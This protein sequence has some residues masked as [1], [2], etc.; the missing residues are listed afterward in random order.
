M[1]IGDLT[2]L[3]N[4][5]LRLLLLLYSQIRDAESSHENS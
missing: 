3:Q 4:Q 5:I 1:R 2:N